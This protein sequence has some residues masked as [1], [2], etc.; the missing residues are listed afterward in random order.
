MALSS[1]RIP[2]PSIVRGC[3]LVPALQAATISRA[4]SAAGDAAARAA[5]EAAFRAR[6][7]IDRFGRPEE[8]AAAV[9]FLLS[10]AAAFVT[11]VA[12]PVDGGSL[13]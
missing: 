6:H 8:V 5:R 13:A 2:R 4:S 10:D 7:P 9:L 1:L 3:T 12:L 11:G